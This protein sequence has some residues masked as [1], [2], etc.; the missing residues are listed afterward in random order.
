MADSPACGRELKLVLNQIPTRRARGVRPWIGRDQRT[1]LRH[2]PVTKSD[3]LFFIRSSTGLFEQYDVLPMTGGVAQVFED[4]LKIEHKRPFGSRRFDLLP[5]GQPEPLRFKPYRNYADEYEATI[6]YNS[7]I[8]GAV[9]SKQRMQYIPP[10]KPP[11]K[12][13]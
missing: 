3:L 8:L 1:D 5:N 6:S 11:K 7:G 12:S 9:L 13:N 2:S 4:R 10:S